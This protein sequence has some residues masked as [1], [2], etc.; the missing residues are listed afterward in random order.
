MFYNSPIR[1]VIIQEGI[2]K[3]GKEVFRNSYYLSDVTLPDTL[4]EIGEGAYFRCFNLDYLRMSDKLTSIGINAFFDTDDIHIDIYSRRGFIEDYLFEGQHI[5]TIYIGNGVFDV[6]E[7]AFANCPYLISVSISDEVQ[8]I[9]E[10]CFF[11]VDDLHIYIRYVDGEI[12]DYV[13][14]DCNTVTRFFIED[15]IHTIGEYAFDSCKALERM[16]LPSSIQNIGS[17]AFYDCNSMTYIN[18]P[19]GVKLLMI[20][21]SLVVRRLLQSNYQILI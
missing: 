21:F 7:M 17:G 19:N 14:K 12:D 5:Y 9:G 13:F 20:T 15:G 8:T 4:L 16:D 11:G 18:V 2:T 10:L 1:S 3:I 6:G